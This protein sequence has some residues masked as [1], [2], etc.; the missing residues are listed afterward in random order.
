VNY[1]P[2]TYYIYYLQTLSSKELGEKLRNKV[3]SA[4]SLI[5]GIYFKYKSSL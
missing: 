5:F 3:P 2:Y 1:N 4:K